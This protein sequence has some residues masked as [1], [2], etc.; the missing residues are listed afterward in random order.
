MVR[1][2]NCLCGRVWVC[3]PRLHAWLL[4]CGVCVCEVVHVACVHMVSVGAQCGC[5][6]ASLFGSTCTCS[7]I[8]TIKVV[9]RHTFPHT[10]KSKSFPLNVRTT[11]S[12]TNP[13]TKT[14]CNKETTPQ[15][16]S[17]DAHRHTREETRAHAPTQTHMTHTHTSTHYI[18]ELVSN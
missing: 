5:S 13:I 2:A 11:T 6:R 17:F 10:P 4:V 1:A 7:H 14:G 3:V 18:R 16:A 9:Q 8:S 15:T 12:R